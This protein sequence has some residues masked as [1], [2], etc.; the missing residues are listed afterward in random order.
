MKK[1]FIT[2]MLC[3]SVAVS[4]L[5]GCGESTSEQKETVVDEGM[6]TDYGTVEIENMDMISTYTKIPER[7]VSLSYA[8]TEILVALG[9]KDKIVGIAEADNTIEVVSDKYKA[10]VEELNIICKSEDGGVPTL[11]GV[12]AQS[13][14]FVYGTSYSFNSK[15]GVGDPSD[16]TENN[17]NIYAST[18]TCNEDATIED[19]YQDII[20]IG[21][22]FKVED[23]AQELV[24][25]MKNK[26][27]AVTEKIKNEEPVTALLFD[28]G[29][30]A[31]YVY[32]ENCYEGSIAKLAGVKNII[33]T[34]EGGSGEISWEKIVEA[35]PEYIIINDW[36]GGEG[37]QTLQE[38]IDYLCSLPELQDVTAI[39]KQQFIAVPLEEICFG[40]LENPDAIE[41]I[42]KALYPEVFED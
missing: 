19:T 10:D 40:T 11:E 23:R 5:A 27:S 13:P 6:E 2:L 15:F 20:N 32:Y 12:L 7:I 17:I 26:V 35:N 42:A 18:S 36:G 24:D 28:S 29:E 31:P 33:E 8:E 39:K 1:K 16:F 14:D 4:M 37:A 41:T 38:K 21:K 22:I 34:G 9:L 30:E 3:A 25:E